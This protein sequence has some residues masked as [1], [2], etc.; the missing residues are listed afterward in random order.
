MMTGVQAR[1]TPRVSEEACRR[2][3]DAPC[4][5]LDGT[6]GGRWR[7]W[8]A[9]ALIALNGQGH[10]FSARHPAGADL[11]WPTA[12]VRGLW[13]HVSADVVRGEGLDAEGEN[14]D[15]ELADALFGAVVRQALGCDPAEADLKAVAARDLARH[16][17]LIED[18]P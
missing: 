8:L 14:V 18:R 7:D 11:N 16:L 4:E 6:R 12:V 10:S 3:L 1:T 13:R 9:G 15:W 5:L 17:G 2:F